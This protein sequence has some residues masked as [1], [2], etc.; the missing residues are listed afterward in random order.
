M[1]KRNRRLKVP[2]HYA[3]T[4]AGLAFSNSGN[5]ICHT[6][7]D[8]VGATFK[9][10]HGR[11]NAIALPYVIKYNS[12]IA[13]DQYAVIARALGYRGEDITGAVGNLMQKISEMKQRLQ[14]PD[15]YREAGIS[16]SAYNA[17][18]K[19]FSTNAYTF[20][21]TVSNPRKPTLE[22]LETLFKACHQGD[23]GLL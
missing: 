23:Y 16:T 2:L 1:G 10:S 11:A 19:A 14:V 20:P 13:G 3:A 18:L 6:I 12:H 9:L 7:A 21:T 17:K 22:E 15:S 8:K 4:I 5:V